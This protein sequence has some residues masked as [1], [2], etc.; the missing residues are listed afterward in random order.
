MRGDRMGTGMQQRDIILL[1]PWAV[2]ATRYIHPLHTQPYLPHPSPQSNAT[3]PLQCDNVNACRPCHGPIDVISGGVRVR[4]RR[5]KHVCIRPRTLRGASPSEDHTST[6][7]SPLGHNMTDSTA[8][9]MIPY[10]GISMHWADF[11]TLVLLSRPTLSVPSMSFVPLCFCNFNTILTRSRGL[12]NTQN[13]TVQ[14]LIVVCSL[15]NLPHSMQG[16]IR[17]TPHSADI[18]HILL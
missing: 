14:T 17:M 3:L 1:E 9:T 11:G 2:G 5:A 12:Q 8:A 6:R 15:A 7:H 16:A 18:S 10:Q 13:S 4:P